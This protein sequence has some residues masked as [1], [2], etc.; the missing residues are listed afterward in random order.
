MEKTEKL[1][2]AKNAEII[3]AHERLVKDQVTAEKQGP[4]VTCDT[5]SSIQES[6]LENFSG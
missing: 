3:I 2:K 5:E 6:V 1:W 4:S